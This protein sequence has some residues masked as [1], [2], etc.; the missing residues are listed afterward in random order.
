[1]TTNTTIFEEPLGATTMMEETWTER[2]LTILNFEWLDWNKTAEWEMF[3]STSLDN[4]VAG[5]S[6]TSKHV[7]L[8][9][10]KNSLALFGSAQTATIAILQNLRASAYLELL[11]LRVSSMLRLRLTLLVIHGRR[12]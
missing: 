8:K 5:K 11:R 10:C 1:M 7:Q 3:L 6:K 12:T 9:R 4:H 2:S